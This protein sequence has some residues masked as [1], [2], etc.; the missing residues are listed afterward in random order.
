MQKSLLVL[1]MGVLASF[2]VNAETLED[3]LKSCMQVKNSLERLSCFEELTEALEHKNIAGSDQKA[4][5]RAPVQPA[6]PVYRQQTATP[7]APVLA[8]NRLMT[9][10]QAIEAWSVE[11]KASPVSGQAEVLVSNQASSGRNQYAVPVEINLA[12]K[13]GALIAKLLWR[14]EQPGGQ[15][16]ELL[17]DGKN[18]G[19]ASNAWVSTD[20]ARN[21][22]YTGGTSS[23]MTA[24]E[25][26]QEASASAKSMEAQINFDDEVID[27]EWKLSGAQYALQP[28]MQYCP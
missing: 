13:S 8:Q 23:L 2:S 17:F 15:D 22:Q 25:S 3:A 4:P 11:L 14:E 28:L 19:E 27:A 12:C 9:G 18:I 24:L 16:L 1:G 21:W 26:H 10:K 20:G 5:P 6:M 7:T